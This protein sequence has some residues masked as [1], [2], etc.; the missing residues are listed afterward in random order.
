MSGRRFITMPRIGW[1]VLLVL[2]G[3]VAFTSRADA[4]CGDYV[5]MNHSDP[6]ESTPDSAPA[7]PSSCK[8]PGCKASRT[9]LAPVTQLPI[10]VRLEHWGAI[11]TLSPVESCFV[12]WVSSDEGLIFPSTCP[13]GILRPPKRSTDIA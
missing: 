7:T 12:R 13:L 2:L 10:V 5:R 11:L 6:Q 9:P 3:S 1:Q 8:G 4:G